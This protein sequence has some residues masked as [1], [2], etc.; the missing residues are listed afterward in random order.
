MAKSSKYKG[1]KQASSLRFIGFGQVSITKI[2]MKKILYYILFISMFIQ[3]C[4][5]ESTEIPFVNTVVIAAYLYA[6]EP[7]TNIKITSLIPFNADS[8]ETFYI[9]DAEVDILHGDDSYRLVL[10]EGDSGYYHYQGEDLEIIAGETYGFHLMYNNQ[11]ITATT[12]VPEE[13]EEIAISLEEIPIEPI[14]EFFDLRN[15]PMIDVDITW[16][17][18]NGTYYYLLIDNVEDDPAPIDVNGILDGFKGGRNFSF[19]TQPTQLDIYRLRGMTLEQYGTHRVKVYKVNQEYADLYESSEQDSRNLNEPLNN[20]NNGL[21]I[22][23]S[24]NSSSI[25]FE[26]VLP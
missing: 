9:N 10:S 13:P 3:A 18:D 14:Y 20:I 6:G 24:F 12:T 19:I 1:M 21:G 4:T 2:H 23:T 17:N 7:V 22:F 25:N 16:Q 26:V 11:D 8:T 5:D 15:R